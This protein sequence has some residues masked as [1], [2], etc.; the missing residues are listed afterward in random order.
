MYVKHL[1]LLAVI[2]TAGLLSCSQD[3]QQDLILNRPQIKEVQVEPNRIDFSAKDLDSEFA[4]KL[5]NKL[6]LNARSGNPAVTLIMAEYLTAGGD[7]DEMGQTVFFNDRGNKQ[8]AFD[9]LA[10]DP[11]SIGGDLTVYAVDNHDGATSSGLSA[12]TT[13]AAI[14]RAM[15]TWDGVNC[16]D[17]MF[18][19]NV[20]PGD[21]GVV[22]AIFGFG[23]DASNFYGDIQHGGFLPGAF[24]DLLAPDGS[25]FI[26]GATF[27]FTWS[28]DLNGDGQQEV[29][30]REIYYNDNFPWSDGSGIDV[31]TIALHEAG[32]G[33]SQGHFGKAFRTTKNG[34][35]HFSPRAV[36]N[37]AYS[38]VQTGIQK[39]DKSGHCSLWADWPNN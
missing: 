22:Q 31:E 2:L 10:G 17:P 8:L 12:G 7:S 33:L 5:Q 23:G 36:M 37:A 19:K 30:F 14:D 9:F 4:K 16:S 18:V 21:I 38:G 34:K 13:E 27:T 29:A 6:T 26:L 20:V 32:H 28:Q 11:R 35:L 3:Q 15:S 1:P 39:T 24:F 25:D